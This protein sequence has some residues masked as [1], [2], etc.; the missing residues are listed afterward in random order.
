VRQ[1]GIGGEVGYGR[2]GVVELGGS[3]GFTIAD[4]YRNVAIAPSIGWFLA[5]NLEL[6]G[7]LSLSY[8]KAGDPGMS[9]V[10]V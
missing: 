10:Q 8:V 7:I 9:A 3:A 5:D 1:A 6:S 2:P 4:N